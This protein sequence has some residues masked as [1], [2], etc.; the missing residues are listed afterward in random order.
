[1]K[2]WISAG[3]V[4][5]LALVAACTE[6]SSQ[7]AGEAAQDG[8]T[9]VAV[10]KVGPAT[11]TRHQFEMAYKYLP[12]QA[13]PIIKEKGLD[14]LLDKLIDAEAA[15][16]EALAQGL[17][18]DPEVRYQIDTIMRTFY[19]QQL[20]KK[21]M[22]KDFAIP[23]A[24]AKAYYDQHADEFKSGLR[25]K[26]RHIVVDDEKTALEVQKKARA[27]ES[28]VALVMQ[29]STDPNKKETSG[30]F[31][32]FE[33][34][35]MLPEIEQA[36]FA[37]KKGD[38]VGPVKTQFGYHV[39]WV[40]DQKTAGVRTFEEVKTDLTNRMTQEKQESWHT[41]FL[42]DLRT[43]YPVTKFPENLPDAAK[44]TPGGPEQP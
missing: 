32:W 22:P 13:A 34:G 23:D 7:K 8:Q 37:G 39:L 16:Q 2:R 24:E 30:D 25:V 9:S 17:D 27:G 26:A 33:K 29:Y 41:K 11:V 15:Y 18:K 12:E 44:T 6:L 3:L 38:I 42:A 35:T 36:V 21:V 20:M 5:V 4:A 10:A 31:G 40:E 28:F 19:Y 43:K 1:M 14:F